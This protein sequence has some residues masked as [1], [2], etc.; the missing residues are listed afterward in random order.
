MLWYSQC[1]FLR[2]DSS[3]FEITRPR[4]SRCV[5]ER[6]GDGRTEESGKVDGNEILILKIRPSSRSLPHLLLSPFTS[7]VSGLGASTQAT[8]LIWLYRLQTRLCSCSRQRE[9]QS[10]VKVRVLLKG[11][12][13]KVLP[14]NRYWEHRLYSLYRNVSRLNYKS[15]SCLSRSLVILPW[16]HSC[17]QIA[18]RFLPY[19]TRKTLGIDLV[20]NVIFIDLLPE[21]NQVRL[22]LTVWMHLPKCVKCLFSLQNLV[23]APNS[24][25]KLCL[26]RTIILH[27]MEI[28]QFPIFQEISHALDFGFTSTW[29][30]ER[31]IVAIIT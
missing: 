9:T 6:E 23:K 29:W 31:N 1:G 16:E 7:P 15:V 11:T 17:L 28:L 2:D 3:W 30:V 10:L 4:R 24:I 13:N 5:G 20:K 14:A 18:L 26:P 22:Q 21:T 25:Y 19:S 12:V 8:K 27:I